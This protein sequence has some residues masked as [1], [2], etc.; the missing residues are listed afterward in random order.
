MSDAIDQDRLDNFRLATWLQEN[1]REY[2]NCKQENAELTAQVSELTKKLAERDTERDSLASLQEMEI[3]RLTRKLAEQQAL[4]T[5]FANWYGKGSIYGES[6]DSA[7]GGTEELTKLLAEARKVPEDGQLDVSAIMEQA[8]VFASAWAIFGSGS[9]FEPDNA[10]EI[11]EEERAK[12]K[13]LLS[14]LPNGE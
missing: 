14:A 13:A 7:I 9:A 8:Q 12:L 2:M 6:Q 1:Q 10:Q 11:A 5:K 3:E 4:L